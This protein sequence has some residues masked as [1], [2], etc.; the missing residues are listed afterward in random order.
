MT[1]T[2]L[3][4]LRSAGGFVG[5]AFVAL[6]IFTP[7]QWHGLA[8]QGSLLLGSLATAW[9]VASHLFEKAEALLTTPNSQKQNTSAI[10]EAVAEAPPISGGVAVGED[11]QQ[12]RRAKYLAMTQQAV[13]KAATSAASLVPAPA[14]VAALFALCALLSGCVLPN[15][16][17]T[18]FHQDDKGGIYISSGKDVKAT[19]VDVTFA[20]G[21]K[22]HADSYSSSANPAT[23][24]AEGVREA[25]DTAAT[26][27][28]AGNVGKEV[29]AGIAASTGITAAG[30]AVS[31]VAALISSKA[32]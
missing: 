19:G 17:T 3:S 13:R 10:G 7:A 20:N 8:G 25:G 5:G 2:T 30:T 9:T 14:A 12:L 29:V 27:T 4:R 32:H 24:T 11:V 6:G 28:A 15:T 22:I 1:Q 16:T 21:E 31:G 18:T 26:G 23:T